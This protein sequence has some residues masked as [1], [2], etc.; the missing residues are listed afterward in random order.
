M[1]EI[2]SIL[3]EKRVFKP[4][5]EFAKKAHIKSFKEYEKIYKESVK[6]PQKFWAGQAKSL[7]HW[8][9]PWNKVLQWNPPFSKWFIGGK[10]NISYNCI[11]RHLSTWRKNKAAIIWECEP[12]DSRTL[13][14]DQLHRE[15]CKF[16]N[17]L[18]SL[19]IKKGDRACIYMPMIPELQKPVPSN[20]PAGLTGKTTSGFK[21]NISGTFALE[22]CAIKSGGNLPGWKVTLWYMTEVQITVSPSWTVYLI[23]GAD[24]RASTL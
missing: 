5:A 6:N 18:K 4:R 17:A 10:I 19:G 9:K 14:Y 16:A 21:V 20:S 3:K 13:T 24:H 8:F 12:G 1:A 15:V 7:L 23:S 11:D 22:I 2:E